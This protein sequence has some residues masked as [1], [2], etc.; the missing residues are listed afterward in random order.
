MLKRK[1]MAK[2]S[3]V[4]CVYNTDEGYFEECLKKIYD[5]TLTDLEVIVVDD[6]SSKD[7]SQ[8]LKT[9][10]KIKYFKNENQGTLKARIFGVKQA[11]SPYVCFVDS[12]DTISFDYFEASLTKALKNNS[13]IVFNDWA[14]HTERT[15]YVCMNDSTIK[16]D[17]AYAGDTALRKFI[18]QAGREHSFYVLWNKVFK[19]EILLNACLKVESLDVGHMVFAEDV[20]ITYFAFADAQ[21]VTN[22]HLGYYFYRMHNSQQIYVQSE[23]KLKNH[24]DS[25]TTVFD[26]MEADLKERGLF[27]DLKIK[28]GLWKQLLCSTNY[29]VAKRNKYKSLYPFILEKYKDCKLKRMPKDAGKAY[30]KQR[31]LPVNLDQIDTA[32]KKVYYSNKYLKIYA[33]KGSYGFE[34]LCQMKVLFDRKFDIIKSKRRATFV[35]PK[36]KITFKQRLLHNP[37]VYKVGMFLF[38]KG[39]K[40]RKFLKSKL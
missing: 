36:E 6:G 31:I 39:S 33:K 7:Y 14:F 32:L 9:Y 10:H 23:T 12:D 20:L 28:F 25:M 4:I 38:P 16:K 17:I 34:S 35:M 37:I 5:S 13:D 3:V 1:I 26:I 19:R 11:T 24:V 29:Q 21:K 15:K 2:L 30:V 18:G 8:I 27:E 40:I 22:T